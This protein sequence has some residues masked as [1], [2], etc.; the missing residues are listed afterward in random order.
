MLIDGLPSEQIPVSDRG[1]QYGDGLFETIAVLKGRMP[2]WSR[3]MARLQ[4]GEEKLGFPLTDKHL[5]EQ[6]AGLLCEGVGQ[7]I[8]KI[9]LTRGSGGRGYRP[10]SDPRPRRIITRHPWPDYPEAWYRDGVRIRLCETR[11]SRQPRLAGIKHLNRLEQVL[12]RREWD[13]P[14][15]A[16]GLMCDDL[17]NLI[18]GTQSNLFLLKGRTLVT[19]ELNDCG[20][21][22]VMREL[23]MAS[24]DGLGLELR[25]GRIRP[26]DLERADGM[27]LTNAI[28]GV[29]P[30]SEASGVVYDLTRLSGIPVSHRLI[31]ETLFE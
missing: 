9:I 7:G 21:A 31:T 12:A 30:V 24:A 29:C 14:G 6:E 5:L 20:V 1:L 15:L 16:E 2:L 3:H 4:R 13:D 18:S 17:G 22:G 26:E 28:W 19:P 25:V 23:V 10:P 8:V 27:F 11:F